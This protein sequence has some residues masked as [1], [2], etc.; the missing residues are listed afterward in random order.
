MNDTNSDAII[1]EIKKLFLNFSLHFWNL[2]KILNVLKKKDH[3][4][5]FCISEITDSKNVVQEMPKQSHFR[6]R[7]DKQHGKRA[8]VLFKSGSHHLYHIHW[9]LPSQLSLKNSLLLRCK[10]LGLLVNTLAADEKYLVLH[11]DNLRIPIQMQLSHKQKTFSQ[12]VAAFLKSIW[13]LERFGKKDN[14]HSFWVSEITGS[15]KVVI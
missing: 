3:P 4:H 8:Q 11:I 5:S 7:F 12:F 9:S 6:E 14:P 15:K 10:I 2:T 1:W 13:I